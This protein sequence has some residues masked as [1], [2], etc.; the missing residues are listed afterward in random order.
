MRTIRRRMT[1][2]ENKECTTNE[3]VAVLAHELGHWKLNHVAKNLII[4]EVNLFFYFCSLWSFVSKRSDIRILW[5]PNRTEACPSWD[6]LSSSNT[7]SLL[8]MRFFPSLWLV[9]HEHLS[10]KQMLFAKSL[11]QQVI[12]G[13]LSSN[14]ITTTWVSPSSTICIPCGT[15]HTLLFLRDLMLCLNSSEISWNSV[16]CHTMTH[17]QSTDNQMTN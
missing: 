15:I 13:L 9:C 7:S 5:F 1:R 12:C 6:S 16:S 2:N 10:S 17:T 8:T 11:Q 4:S 14:S 3:V